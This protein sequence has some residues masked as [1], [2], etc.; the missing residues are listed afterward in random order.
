MDRE[1][2]HAERSM[3]KKNEQEHGDAPRLPTTH[4][5]ALGCMMR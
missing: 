5:L 2:I 3:R 1:H 4:A